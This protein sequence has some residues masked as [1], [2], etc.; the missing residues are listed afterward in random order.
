[1]R[2]IGTVLSSNVC[3]PPAP[4]PTRRGLLKGL[5]LAPQLLICPR[6][7]DGGSNPPYPPFPERGSKRF[8]PLCGAFFIKAARSAASLFPYPFF[9]KRGGPAGAGYSS[10][11]DVTGAFEKPDVLRAGRQ[12]WR[13][14]QGVLSERFRKFAPASVPG[15]PPR[16]RG[17]GGQRTLDDRAVPIKQIRPNSAV[18][19]AT[20]GGPRCCFGL[21]PMNAV[22][23]AVPGDPRSDNIQ[24]G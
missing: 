21:P 22:G 11:W 24:F 14:L 15:P 17:A 23:V 3:C 8:A 9:G 4:P 5:R 2:L 16:R 19:A 13:P 18:G 20:P 6:G 12:E 1:M 7:G 10:P